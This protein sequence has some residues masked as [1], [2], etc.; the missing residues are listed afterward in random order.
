MFHMRND[1]DEKIKSGPQNKRSSEAAKI[2]KQNIEQ[3]KA[4]LRKKTERHKRCRWLCSLRTVLIS[5]GIVGIVSVK[6]AFGVACGGGCG[7][8]TISSIRHKLISSLHPEN[9][10]FFR[11]KWPGFL[12]K[13]LPSPC[14]FCRGER[15]QP[16][17]RSG[18]GL[19]IIMRFQDLWKN[20]RVELQV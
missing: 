10:F 4:D 8:A 15:P 17:G 3:V 11:C 12:H 20:R 1:W 13:G 9:S 16:C 14:Q 5:M 19:C 6:S 7:S 2:S 18:W